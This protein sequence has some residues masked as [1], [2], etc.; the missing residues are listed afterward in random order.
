[1][2]LKYNKTEP[3][4]ITVK[5]FEPY[6]NKFVTVAFIYLK[7]NNYKHLMFGN[8]KYHIVH[9]HGYFP[10]HK[11]GLNVIRYCKRNFK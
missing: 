10:N 11:H 4:K 7:C 1:M 6:F 8:E 5:G 2:R 9:C 3:N